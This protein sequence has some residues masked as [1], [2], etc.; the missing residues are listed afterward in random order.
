V[1]R[2]CSFLES[3]LQR[4]DVPVRIAPCLNDEVFEKLRVKAIEEHSLG[5]A[6]GDGLPRG[7]EALAVLLKLGKVQHQVVVAIACHAD[8]HE[9]DL[10]VVSVDGLVVTDGKLDGQEQ[11]RQVAT[12]DAG[13]LLLDL[14]G[15]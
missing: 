15:E 5:L 7:F 4:T 11:A 6:V 2:G 12:V 8:L 10:Q 14:V 9:V 13:G 1:G 3:F